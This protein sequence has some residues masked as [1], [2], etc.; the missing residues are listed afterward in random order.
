MK[1]RRF[2]TTGAA[3]GAARLLPA[4]RWAAGS[5]SGAPSSTCKGVELR[6]PG[7][8]EVPPRHRPDGERMPSR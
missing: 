1:R 3:T 2:L 4:Y 8:G 6:I 7:L 5:T